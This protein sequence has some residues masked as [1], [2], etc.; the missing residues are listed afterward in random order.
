MA[1]T[2]A[3]ASEI[4]EGD[5]ETPVEDMQEA[6]PVVPTGETDE[7]QDEGLDSAARHAR[8]QSHRPRIAH[9]K[10]GVTVAE[11]DGQRTWVP[12]FD[13]GQRIVVE[14]RTRFLKDD[15]WLHTIVGKVRSI[16]DDT[17][18]VTMFDEDTDVRLQAVRYVSFKDE[19]QTFKLAPERGNPFDATKVRVKPELKPGEVRRGRGRP[20]GSSN[21]PK[22]VI[23]AEREARKAAKRGGK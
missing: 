11:L 15:P 23:Q 16:D 21:R 17:G 4:F 13:V 7:T 20:K 9:L 22:E 10:D 18:V 12:L 19:L 6:P 14:V 1:N 3:D 5:T 8:W 2:S